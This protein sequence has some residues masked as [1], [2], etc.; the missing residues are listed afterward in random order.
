MLCVLAKKNRSKDGE[1]HRY[2][3][4]GESVE[5][6]PPEGG[7]ECRTHMQSQEKENNM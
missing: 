3:R 6:V 4:R 1:R 5:Q 2:P 7:W